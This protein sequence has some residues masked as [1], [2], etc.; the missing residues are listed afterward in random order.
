MNMFALFLLCLSQHDQPEVNK[1]DEKD[2]LSIIK[3]EN[4]LEDDFDIEL[5]AIT[6]CWLTDISDSDS[7]TWICSCISDCES[8]ESPESSEESV[9]SESSEESE[10][11]ESSEELTTSDPSTILGMDRTLFI[12]IVVVVACIVIVILIVAIVAYRKGCGKRPNQNE[13]LTESDIVK[14]HKK[15]SDFDDDDLKDFDEIALWV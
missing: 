9:I 12:I 5:L 3:K 2:Y 6:S 10:T 8:N 11:S 15:K 1:Q 14:G 4:K 7:S 13:N